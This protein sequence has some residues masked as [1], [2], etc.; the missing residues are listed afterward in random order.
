MNRKH[1]ANVC[2]T[3]NIF[4]SIPNVAFSRPF[5][6]NVFISMFSLSVIFRSS[7]LFFVCS[8]KVLSTDIYILILVLRLLKTNRSLVNWK[9]VKYQE[10]LP[11]I[12]FAE[13][14]IGNIGPTPFVCIT[15]LLNPHASFCSHPYTTL[16]ASGID[17]C[18]V[19][20]R[21]TFSNNMVTN[22]IGFFI[23]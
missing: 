7:H 1:I 17:R 11:L 15:L 9:Y 22:L 14:E 2:C 13:S 21:N 3:F 18:N 16:N 23:S 8:A 20:S 5:K 4:A 6:S 10:M 19:V 12:R